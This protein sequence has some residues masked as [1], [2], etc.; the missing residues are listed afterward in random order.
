MYPSRA[1]TEP[2]PHPQFHTDSEL[3]AAEREHLEAGVVVPLADDS[4]AVGPAA[5]PRLPQWSAGEIL[6]RAP[7]TEPPLTAALLLILSD[8]PDWESF[9]AMRDSM[10]VPKDFLK[11][12][13]D[14]RP[15][16]DRDLF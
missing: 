3:E 10:D 1:R 11:G 15:P 6:A 8:K 4:F 2:Q 9:F 14:K 12:I 7:G 16:E 5:E 13:R